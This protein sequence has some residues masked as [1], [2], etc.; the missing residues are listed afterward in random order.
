M[1]A[2]LRPLPIPS[3]SLVSLLI[4]QR[5]RR[6]HRVRNLSQFSFAWNFEPA[7][8]QRYSLNVQ[9]AITRDM[10]LEVGYVGA[11]G[12]H[13]MQEQY[14]NQAVDATVTPIRG[15]STNTVANLLDR[16][17]VQGFATYSWLQIG[18]EG[19]S[20]YNGLEASLTKR[21]SHGLQFLASYTWAKEIASDLSASTGV[22]GGTTIGNQ[23]DASARSGP[24]YFIRPQRF[25]V[26]FVY[27]P[28]FF[29]DR[30]ALMRTALAGWKIA[31]V[32]QIQSGHQ[33][34][35]ENTNASNLFGLIAPDARLCRG[36]AELQSGHLG[37]HPKAN[38]RLLQ[39]QLLSGNVS[40]DQRGWGHG[41][42]Q[43][44]AGSSSWACTK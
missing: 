39:H 4:C 15:Q 32:T 14:P 33:L 11:R 7:L 6:T 29:Q 42:R 10:L 37:V 9:T 25:V 3:R 26:S 20:W 40:G 19:T 21:F 2:Q 38:R 36:V 17:P 30:G 12:E 1:G 22:N 31:G 8:I 44:P 5:L 34:Y 28:P 41:I 16:V 23:Y 35:V 18:S 13:L 27:A 24:D 43:Q